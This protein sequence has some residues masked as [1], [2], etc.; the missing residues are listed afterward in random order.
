MLLNS[1][2]NHLDIIINNN[3]NPIEYI[4]N[5]YNTNI[6]KTGKIIPN[7][8]IT[9]LNLGPNFNCYKYNQMIILTLLS[10][11]WKNSIQVKYNDSFSQ[12]SAW[13]HFDET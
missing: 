3:K 10:Q 6:Q 2:F 4:S 13:T 7:N 5:K 8:I 1:R 9:F 11:T 12:K